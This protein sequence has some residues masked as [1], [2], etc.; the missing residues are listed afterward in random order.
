MPTPD[1]AASIA[2]L[3]WATIAI[4][5]VLAAFMGLLIKQWIVP[6]WVYREKVAELGIERA[7]RE[8]AEDQLERSTDSHRE[9]LESLLRPIHHPSDRRDDPH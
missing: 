8:K 9:L 4:L 2:D 6:G 7:R 5:L 3:G 1:L